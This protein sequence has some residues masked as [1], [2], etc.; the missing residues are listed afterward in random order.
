MTPRQVGVTVD[1][2]DAAQLAAFWERF[3]GYA[4]RPGGPGSAYVTI[5]RRDDGPDGPPFVTF[6]TVPEP[7]EGKARLHLDLFVDHARPLV[8]EMLVAGASSVLTD[9]QPLELAR[10]TPSPASREEPRTALQVPLEGARVRERVPTNAPEERARAAARRLRMGH[11]VRAEGHN[12]RLTRLTGKEIVMGD[13][14][15]AVTVL[16]L[17]RMGLA[18]TQA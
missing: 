13:S 1:C 12:S 2:A 9:H 11:Y 18:L 15:P 4:R 10:Q 16:G 3:L 6:Q 7:K 8:D 14:A 17:G 5:E